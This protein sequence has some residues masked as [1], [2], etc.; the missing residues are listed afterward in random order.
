MFKIIA[1]QA[2][3]F[4]CDKKEGEKKENTGSNTSYTTGRNPKGLMERAGAPP[5]ALSEKEGLLKRLPDRARGMHFIYWERHILL[6]YLRVN[7]EF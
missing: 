2:F 7:N 3:I 6:D 5:P 1:F 4:F